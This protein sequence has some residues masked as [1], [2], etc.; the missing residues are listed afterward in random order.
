MK[1]SADGRNEIIAH[2]A[3]VLSPYLD[4]KNVWTIGVGVTKAAGGIDPATFKG[5]LTLQQA[6]DM[7]AAKLTQ[8]ERDVNAAFTRPLKQHE[9]D[10]AVSFHWNTGAI[11]KATW[12]KSFNAG[13]RELAIK[14][15]MNW[16]KDKELIARR[17]A[18]QNL[19]ATGQYSNTGTAMVYPA[20]ASG[21]V[22]WSKGKRI[23]LDAIAPASAP[24]STANI[25]PKGPLPIPANPVPSADAPISQPETKTMINLSFLLMQR[26]FWAAALGLFSMITG[27]TALAGYGVA[28]D[29]DTLIATIDLPKVMTALGAG[30]GGLA[31]IL[32]G[33]SLANP[34]G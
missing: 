31:G 1:T 28:L 16:T 13:N 12:V 23:K 17:E 29:P 32:A 34:K 15:I 24:P 20:S 33:W 14:Q 18:E 2:E 4:S 9:Y 21:A 6:L 25:D 26:R 3:I 22:Q 27:G 8:Y 10:A 30:S 19:F 11:K 7:F 5:K